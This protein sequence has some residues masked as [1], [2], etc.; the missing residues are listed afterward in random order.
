MMGKL[1]INDFQKE[2]LDQ[3]NTQKK[4]KTNSYEYRFVKE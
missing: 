4:R 1:R 3:K 2:V